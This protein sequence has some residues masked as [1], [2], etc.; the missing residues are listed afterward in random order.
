MLYE[1][2]NFNIT[3]LFAIKDY[4]AVAYVYMVA[5]AHRVAEGKAV[6]NVASV[7]SFFLSR[8]DV[9]VDQFLGDHFHEAMMGE[10]APPAAQLFGKV[11][12]ANAKLVYQR[13]KQIF[14]GERWQVLERCGAHVQRPLRASSSTQ[15]PL[16][17]KLRYVE[18]LIGPHPVNTMPDETLAAFAE[19]VVVRENTV[20]AEVGAAKRTMQD[21]QH[22]GIDLKCITWQ[23]PNEGVKKF[24]EPFDQL[25]QP[26]A[27]LL[28]ALLG[29]E[30]R[31]TLVLGQMNAAVT[32]A[33]TA[34]DG[35][36][37]P[38]GNP[39]RWPG[40][41]TGKLYRHCIGR[42]YLTGV[43]PLT[44]EGRIV[45]PLKQLSLVA[46]PSTRATTVRN[47]LLNINLDGCQWSP[48]CGPWLRPTKRSRRAKRRT[49]C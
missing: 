7:A 16:Y 13:F 11:A 21:L 40:C 3:L 36:Q 23:L 2:I 28:Q 49:S 48:M 43:C 34:L 45:A 32:A 29:D 47:L 26:L 33:C 9:L 44:D 31:Q 20:E 4:E 19:R 39:L 37:W 18:P 24:R 12:I 38:P 1:G 35:R 27:E 25:M 41:P 10:D 5:L 30:G 42:L 46:V 15:D 8:I 14:H 22:V 6:R 17:D